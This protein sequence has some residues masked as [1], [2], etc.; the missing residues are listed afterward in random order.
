[1][2]GA[3]STIH[4]HLGRDADTDSKL[5]AERVRLHTKSLAAGMIP[6]AL[7]DHQK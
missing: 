5:A 6:F 7:A 3:I 1:L 4:Q 2:R